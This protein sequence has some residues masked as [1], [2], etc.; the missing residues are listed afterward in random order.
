MQTAPMPQTPGRTQQYQCCG[1]HVKT[2]VMLVADSVFSLS[3]YTNVGGSVAANQ[4]LWDHHSGK[5]VRVGLWFKIPDW[6]LN[7]SL[8]VCVCVRFIAQASVCLC[9][10]C[11]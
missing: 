8:Q 4:Y 6:A 2:S 3:P 7:V 9:L 1:R 10:L 11:H 5:I